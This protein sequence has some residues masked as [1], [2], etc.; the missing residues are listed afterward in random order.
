MLLYRPYL[1]M[2][3]LKYGYNFNCMVYVVYVVMKSLCDKND[4]ILL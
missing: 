3:L 4:N 2:T 1:S